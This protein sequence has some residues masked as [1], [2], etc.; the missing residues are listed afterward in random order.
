MAVF[1]SDSL[2]KVHFSHP[3]L[4]NTDYNDVVFLTVKMFKY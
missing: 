2:K 1:M 4:K 3:E